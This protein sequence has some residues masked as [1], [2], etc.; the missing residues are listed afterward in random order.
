MPIVCDDRRESLCIELEDAASPSEQKRARTS[1]DDGARLQP[2]ES[3]KEVAL[4]E[5][6]YEDEHA[7]FVARR[8]VR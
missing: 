6:P 3:C 8:P 5:D 1:G 7:V 4:V 2:G